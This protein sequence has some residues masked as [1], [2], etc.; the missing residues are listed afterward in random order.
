MNNFIKCQLAVT[1][2]IIKISRNFKNSLYSEEIAQ[3]YF[4]TEREIFIESIYVKV[5][6]VRTTNYLYDVIDNLKAY[7]LLLKYQIPK[8]V[9][10]IALLKY[11]TLFKIY[12]DF[13]KTFRVLEIL[14]CL[15][16]PRVFP[17]LFFEK[18]DERNRI[19]HACL[20]MHGTITLSTLL[21]ILICITQ[22]TVLLFGQSTGGILA[23]LI[24]TLP[25]ANGLFSSVISES[26]AG[27]PLTT[28]EQQIANGNQ[29]VQT[30]GC[31]NAS[32]VSVFDFLCYRN[33][34]RIRQRDVFV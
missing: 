13:Q 2:G 3:H 29:V 14:R 9:C 18:I 16:K 21:I 27:R 23:H 34:V 17:N 12:Q 26:G 4:T 19:L 25:Q 6:L 31:F 7:K 1:Q 8:P 15:L 11:S 28:T 5:S 33:K 32:D 20:T 24:S 30:L 10:V 22:N